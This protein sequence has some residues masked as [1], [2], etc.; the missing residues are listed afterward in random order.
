MPR[1]SPRKAISKP[2]AA[3]A[4]VLKESV[5]ITNGSTT[6]SV[7]VTETKVALKKPAPKKRQS[8][9]EDD[10][11]CDSHHEDEDKKPAKRRKT[12]GKKQANMVPPSRTAVGS[13]KKAMYIGAHVS[14]AGGILSRLIL[15]SRLWKR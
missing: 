11:E 8:R 9:D 1:S 12:A 6:K 15:S 10:F 2:A 5:A 13:L 4:T 7:S 3:E 14:A